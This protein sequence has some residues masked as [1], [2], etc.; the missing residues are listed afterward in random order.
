MVD[1]VASA[2]AVAAVGAAWAAGAARTALQVGV[3]LRWERGHL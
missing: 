3:E 1:Y 2:R